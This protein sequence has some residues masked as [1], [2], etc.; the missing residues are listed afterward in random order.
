ME[1]SLDSMKHH[2]NAERVDEALKNV[3]IL[4]GRPLLVL[5]A[6]MEGLVECALITR[7]SGTAYFVRHC[8]PVDIMKKIQTFATSVS[9]Y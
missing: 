3:R 5:L 4:A 8:K 7:H 2:H 9:N 6:S 1:K